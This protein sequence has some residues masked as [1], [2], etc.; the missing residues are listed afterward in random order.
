MEICLERYRDNFG[1][2]LVWLLGVWWD[3][4]A[5]VIE[6]H[7]SLRSDQ[8]NLLNSRRDY[9]ELLRL[10]TEEK[11]Q[12]YS[13]SFAA[14]REQDRATPWLILARS[15]RHRNQANNRLPAGMMTEKGRKLDEREISRDSTSSPR[16]AHGDLAY[17][18]AGASRRR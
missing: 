2:L 8:P 10:A 11:K 18:I 4:R 1:R 9:E 16:R 13:P 3:L 12:S 6:E 14:I 5:Q 7:R 15:H 17:G